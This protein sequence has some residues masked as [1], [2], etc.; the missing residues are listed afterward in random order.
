MN[1]LTILILIHIYFTVFY[2]FFL[3]VL[4]H[5]TRHKLNR[6]FMY[7]ILLLSLGLPFVNVHDW[8]SS[9]FNS[10]ENTLPSYTLEKALSIQ[11]AQIESYYNWAETLVNIYF[12]VA[13]LFFFFAVVTF[14]HTYLDKARLNSQA[15]S[16]FKFIKISPELPHLETIMAHEQ[17]HVKL[18][19]SLDLLI[20]EVLCTC[21][22]PNP[23]VIYLKKDLRNIHEFEADQIA[24]KLLGTKSYCYLLLSQ[25]LEVSPHI[26][27]NQF[28]EKATIK[29]RITMLTKTPSQSPAWLKFGF[30]TVSFIGLVIGLSSFVNKDKIQ[31]KTQK[32]GQE[33]GQAVQ[34]I[35]NRKAENEKQNSETLQKIESKITISKLDTVVKPNANAKYIVNGIEVN[36]LN[37]FNPEDIESVSVIKAKNAF[38][39]SGSNGKY[40]V[41]QIKL[42]D[43]SGNLKLGSTEFNVIVRKNDDSELTKVNVK[44]N[45]DN[46]EVKNGSN[47][48]LIDLVSSIPQEEVSTKADQMTEFPGGDDDMNKHQED[49]VFSEV[50]QVPEFPGGNSEM[51]K[52]L[53]MNIR[54]PKEAQM[55]NISGMV[56]V[57]F[58]IEK[59]GSIS[60]IVI[61]KGIGAGCDEEAIRVLK[62]MPKWKPAMQN[63]KKVRCYFNMP[64]SYK[65][66]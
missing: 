27:V 40:D 44:L 62:A 28:F 16:F 50:E 32:L 41:I 31:T 7:I 43:K 42:K 17:A 66:D 19:H 38:D 13:A 5:D 55:K 46:K 9:F 11:V 23:L 33:I 57:K 25:T 58:I 10:S 64:I 29:Q 8:L 4:R 37:G 20:F 24:A 48:K 35:S 15:Y 65:L 51:Y 26:F 45:R 3:L 47:E 53:G 21:L 22:W 2:G 12:L 6:A 36:D 49:P 61:L 52:F 1:T 34:G 18:W 56:F 39:V 54:Y 59:N 60:N 63:N 14:V 30:G